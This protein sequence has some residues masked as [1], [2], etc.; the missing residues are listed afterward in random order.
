MVCNYYFHLYATNDNT[1]PPSRIFQILKVGT[2]LLTLLFQLDCQKK[3]Q[4]KNVEKIRMNKIHIKIGIFE[5]ECQFHHSK[6]QFFF[7]S[8]ILN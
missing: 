3:K 7:G 4:A 8:F 5:F 2:H 1:Y 6:F